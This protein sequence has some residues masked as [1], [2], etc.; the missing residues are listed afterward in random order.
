MLLRILLG[1]FLCAGAVGA[2]V[3][4]LDLVMPDARF[5]AGVDIE[6]VRASRIAQELWA[7]LQGRE[8][9]LAELTRQTGFDPL[10]DLSEVLIASAGGTKPSVLFIAR[11][12]FDRTDL[13]QVARGRISGRETYQGV[14]ILLAEEKEGEPMALAFLDPKLLVAGDPASV[15]GAIA[16][17]GRGGLPAG[18][19]RRQAEQ[20]MAR[21]DA[22]GFSVVPVE[23]LAVRASNEQLSGILA[24]DLM[25]A[26]EQVGGGVRLG[27]AIELELR[28]V[29]R[30]EKEAADLANALRFFAGMLQ[31]REPAAGSYIR[32]LGVEGRTMK[33]AMTIPEAEVRRMMSM[34]T[35]RAEGRAEKPARSAQ[36]ADTGVTIYS[37]PSDMGVV[38]IPAPGRP[39]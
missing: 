33:L 35:V 9:E 31:A 29:S 13:A 26:V 27:Q 11:G 23:E 37:S 3:R 30:S 36:P 18:E 17:R 25:K 20:L 10:R 21:F 5:L 19:M 15:R 24:G 16:R 2:Q 38:K 1:G 7:Q 32:E 22:W 12:A 34:L 28:T 14:E 8:R 6:R 4:L 39:Q